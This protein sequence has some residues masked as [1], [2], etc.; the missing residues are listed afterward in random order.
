MEKCPHCN[1]REIVLTKEGEYVCRSCGSV[2]GVMYV[3]PRRKIT[4]KELLIALLRGY[5]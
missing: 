3:Q 5:A 2:L 1:S 4:R